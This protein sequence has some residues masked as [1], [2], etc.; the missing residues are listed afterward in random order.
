[1][2]LN[3]RTLYLEETEADDKIINT[4]KEKIKIDMR[5]TT[6]GQKPKLMPRY[7]GSNFYMGIC[8]TCKEDIAEFVGDDPN[9]YEG[10]D[11]VDLP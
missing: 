1:M 6:C 4:E 11:Y 2:K 10:D 8:N 9:G 5:C 7:V 3:L